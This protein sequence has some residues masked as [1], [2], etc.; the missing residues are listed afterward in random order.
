MIK[1]WTLVA[2]GAVV[3]A[4]LGTIA[5]F[6]AR[7]T[8]EGR[9]LH[10]GAVLDAGDVQNIDEHSWLGLFRTESGYALRAIRP[11]VDAVHNEVFENPGD[12]PSGRV[13]RAEEGDPQPLYLFSG[14]T[15]LREGP[16]YTAFEGAMHLRPGFVRLGSVGAPSCVLSISAEESNWE[17]DSHRDYAVRLTRWIEG[18]QVDQIILTAAETYFRVPT[19]YWSGDLDGDGVLDFIIDVNPSLEGSATILALFLS[20]AAKEGEIVRI[21]AEIGFGGC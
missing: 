1:K 18:K 19:L 14:L 6:A 8:F 10:V 21:V 11:E 2:C 9:L 7:P 15:A 5:A 20:S 17:R 12:P 4:C 16:V 13:V 3:A